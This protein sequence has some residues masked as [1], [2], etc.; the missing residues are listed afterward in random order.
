ML[1][2]MSTKGKT[3]KLRK[4]KGKRS[5]VNVVRVALPSFTTG[6]LS[7]FN[8]TGNVGHDAALRNVRIS[9]RNAIAHDFRI[10]GRD[11]WISMAR[12]KATLTQG[13]KSSEVEKVG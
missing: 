5:S 2:K 11:I 10:I 1:I 8:V 6:L 9:D 13:S 3:H 12:H 4:S 7:I